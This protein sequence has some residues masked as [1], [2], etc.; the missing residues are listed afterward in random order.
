M[1]QAIVDVP[2]DTAEAFSRA[3]EHAAQAISIHMGGSTR[4][5]TALFGASAHKADV[6]A[7]IE[8]AA[9]AADCWPVAT[10]INRLAQRD[11]IANGLVGLD[12]VSVGGLRIRGAHLPARVGAGRRNLLVNAGRAFGTGHHETTRGCLIALTRLARHHRVRRALDMGTG[13][14]IL[15]MAIARL[16]PA[17]V[18]AVDNDRAAVDVA[19]Q[20]IIANRLGAQVRVLYGMGFR[21]HAIAS[22]GPFE[23][24]TANILASPLVDMAPQIARALAP[25]GI[26]VLAGLLRS[27]EYWVRNA[28]RAAGLRLVAHCRDS[29]WPTLVM[30]RPRGR[31]RYLSSAGASSAGERRSPTSDESTFKMSAM[32]RACRLRP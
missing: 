12:E 24:I 3:L 23:L 19:R 29:D 1:W 6:R 9:R 18:L 4:R 31:W 10:T 20:T 11:W 17:R 16:W 7:K 8:I 21:A 13:T 14:G 27:Q 5:I 25:G 22:T 30:T 15:A 26:V 28:Q 32:A 2:A